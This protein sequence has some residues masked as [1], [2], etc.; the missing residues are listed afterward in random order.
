MSKNLPQKGG[1]SGVFGSVCLLSFENDICL[2]YDA[3][4]NLSG[5]NRLILKILGTISLGDRYEG[6][7]HYTDGRLIIGPDVGWF[8][9]VKMPAQSLQLSSSKTKSNNALQLTAYSLRCAPAS[10]SS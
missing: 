9:E 7:I 6:M 5:R 8:D 4:P 2:S 1:G 10:G 3:K